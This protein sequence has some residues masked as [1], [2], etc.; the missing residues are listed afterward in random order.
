MRSAEIIGESRE[1]HA[2]DLPPHLTGRV[3]GGRYR[4]QTQKWFAMRFEGPD[5]EI[6]MSPAG[7][8]PEFDAWR[9]A[10]I[11]ELLAVIVPFK[12]DVYAQIVEEFRVHSRTPSQE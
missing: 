9:W 10:P 7:H 4:G 2:Y 5:S 1:W 3:W 6:N 12:R 8:D 11:D